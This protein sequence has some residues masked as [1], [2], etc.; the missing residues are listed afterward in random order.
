MDELMRLPSQLAAVQSEVV[1]TSGRLG[2]DWALGAE[3]TGAVADVAL[4]KQLTGRVATM[5]PVDEMDSW[6]APRLHCALR[7][8]RRIASDEGM[9]TWLSLQC[10]SFIVAR[11]QKGK[12]QLHP[13]RYRGAWSRN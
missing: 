12:E 5:L 3:P 7:I 6:L 4:V 11:F 9:W 8:P 1:A 13:W 2:R 10:S